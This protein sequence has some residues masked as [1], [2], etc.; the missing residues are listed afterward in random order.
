MAET[1]V[2]VYP[3]YQTLSIT[4][5]YGTKYSVLWLLKEGTDR[6]AFWFF[7]QGATDRRLRKI[8]EIP[9]DVSGR[10]DVKNMLISP[11]EAE[12]EHVR[13][14]AAQLDR[15]SDS[16]PHTP[17]PDSRPHTPTG[18]PVVGQQVDVMTAVAEG[19][20]NLKPVP[21]IRTNPLEL[22]SDLLDQ[23]KNFV[24]WMKDLELQ[25]ETKR[26]TEPEEKL[27]FLKAG[28]RAKIVEMIG[29]QPWK[30]GQADASDVYLDYKARAKA[31]LTMLHSM[32]DARSKFSTLIQR[33]G[34]DISAFGHRVQEGAY[35]CEWGAI[36]DEM[37]L[38]QMI[39][40]SIDEEWRKKV[41]SADS[42]AGMSLNQAITLAQTMVS[43]R[44]TSQ[45]IRSRRSG[46]AI[47]YTHRD[48]NQQQQP[49]TQ[50]YN[51]RSGGRENTGRPDYRQQPNRPGRPNA[52][53]Y[54]GQ[55]V[56]RC[57]FCLR[58][59][60]PRS[61]PSWGMKCRKCGGVGHFEGSKF[62]RDGYPPRSNN[63]AARTFQQQNAPPRNVNMQ[64]S[65]H[66]PN[67]RTVRYMGDRDTSSYSPTNQE[68][69]THESEIATEDAAG[70]IYRVSRGPP[71]YGPVF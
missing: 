5:I 57:D 70:A 30:S 25:L 28:L 13:Q 62:C 51:D 53:G 68:G 33:P 44:A 55:N 36:Q 14:A 3:G 71:A 12:A 34:E 22:S 41:L 17:T 48:Q 35:L 6:P 23:T 67:N 29:N 56:G 19:L 69:Q 26:V 37:V 66:N 54:S 16:R 11:E 46:Q 63:Q 20:K 24:I 4:P 2:P 39:N 65:G 58:Q 27:R 18:A 1:E 59:H 64:Q 60:P 10:P 40:G 42:V 8:R 52:G 43:I 32:R 31:T 9:D 45:N 7:D 49:R 61:C 15:N 21:E 47:N 38:Q 50:W